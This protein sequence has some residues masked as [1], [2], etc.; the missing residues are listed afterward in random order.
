MKISSIYM[1]SIHTYIHTYK[2]TYIHTYNHTHRYHI[3]IYF[4]SHSN[5]RSPRTVYATL[6]VSALSILSFA[7]LA[8]IAMRADSEERPV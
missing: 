7:N 6:T 1:G 2:R 8:A 4:L 5:V 3:F